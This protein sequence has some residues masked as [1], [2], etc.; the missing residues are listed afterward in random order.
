M[1]TSLVLTAIFLS[2]LSYAEVHLAPVKHLYVPS[3]FDSN[4]AVEVVV[5]GS[6]PNSCFGRNTVNVE[7]HGDVVDIEVT[8]IKKKS[9]ACIDMIIPY[10]E[11]ISIGNLQGGNYSVRVNEVLEESLKVEEASSN[12][13]DDHIYAAIDQIDETAP[14]QFVLK[15][16]RYSPCVVLDEVKVVSNNKD[17]LS[18]MP[19]MKQVST[20]CPMKMTPVS[21]P[22]KLNFQSL[23]TTEP[24]LHV[25]TM[26][27]KS[28]NKII[29][30][31]GRR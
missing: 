24:L 10:Q 16:W 30:L 31:S 4:D 22:V 12:S 3:G 19:V 29:N 26:D 15:G 1:K 14:G 21:Y 25:R 6:F 9:F 28:F 7:V 13:V 2:S 23:K 18:L 20:F 5:S 11:V 27:G 17:T 8:A